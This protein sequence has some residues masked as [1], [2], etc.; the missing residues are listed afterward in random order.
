MDIQKIA[1][2]CHEANRALCAVIGDN[3][4]LPWADAPEWQR[5]SAV[6]QVKWFLANPHAP[7][8]AV[9]DSWMAA[10]LAD[11]WAHGPAKDADLK[12]HPCLVPFDQLPLEQQA[13]DKLFKAV[14]TALV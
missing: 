5:S 14:V 13:K 1:Q 3:S 7:D 8:S 10:K 6:D 4:Q 2:V 12:T 11:G 9:H